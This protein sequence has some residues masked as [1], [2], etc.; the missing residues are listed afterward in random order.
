MVHVPLEE[1]GAGG[2]DS[3]SVAQINAQLETRESVVSGILRLIFS[4][5]IEISESET[6]GRR[7]STMSVLGYYPP[8]FN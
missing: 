8:L 7:R 1:D 3:S 6:T 2:H 4:D 5:G